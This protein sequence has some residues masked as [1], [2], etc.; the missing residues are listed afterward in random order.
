MNT[1]RF[2]TYKLQFPLEYGDIIISEIKIRRP[3]GAQLERIPLRAPEAAAEYAEIIAE[4]CGQ[5]PQVLK[6][7]EGDDWVEV[8]KI[9]QGFLLPMLQA[10]S[11]PSS[12]SP[13]SPSA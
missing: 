3:K 5:P 2:T 7:L 12:S 9:F 11:G 4:M 13:E 6:A 10:M 8:W 1:D